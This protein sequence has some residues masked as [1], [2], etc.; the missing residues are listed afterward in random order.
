MQDSALNLLLKEFKLWGVKAHYHDLQ[1]GHIK[2]EWRVSPDKESRYY[3]IPKTAGDHRSWLNAR[4]KIRQYFKADG[5]VLKDEIVKPKP[6]LTK[7]LAMPEQVERD[8]DQIK[9]LRAEVSALTDVILEISTFVCDLVKRQTTA[10]QA[11]VAPPP[12]P[13]IAAAPAMT[14]KQEVRAKKAFEYLSFN[15]NST[16]VLA[17]D[18][19]VSKQIA[20]RKLY[21][22]TKGDDAKVEMQRGLWRKKRDFDVVPAGV[23]A[24]NRKKLNGHANGKLNGNHH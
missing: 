2:M 24:K 15:W 21:H 18:M 11:A 13:V 6:V 1:S 3:I 23:I 5:L 20:Y 7:A 10:E 22:L 12:E 4:S 9:L 8:I 19:G 17:R 14:E 16:D